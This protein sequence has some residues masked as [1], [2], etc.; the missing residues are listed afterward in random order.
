MKA[1]NIAQAIKNHLVELALN[2]QL[3]LDLTLLNTDPIVDIIKK[4]IAKF[5]D[6]ITSD[7]VLDKAGMI[8]CDDELTIEEQVRLIQGMS[9]TPDEP[10]DYIEGVSVCSAAEYSYTV[11]TFI[12]AIG[13]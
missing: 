11:S 4:E 10:I 13:L 8:L 6:L 7:P 9:D 5:D 2:D 3:P 1:E 12:D